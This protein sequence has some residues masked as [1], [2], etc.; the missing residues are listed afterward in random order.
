M[1]HNRSFFA[2]EL[3]NREESV[4]FQ[5]VSL[6]YHC[7]HPLGHVIRNLTWNLPSASLKSVLHVNVG[8]AV[9][10]PVWVCYICECKVF[11][12][13]HTNA[14]WYTPTVI[15]PLYL[16]FHHLMNYFFLFF[17]R[18]TWKPPNMSAGCVWPDWSFIRLTRVACKCFFFCF[19]CFLTCLA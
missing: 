3:A 4:Q 1:S 7:T 11:E 9:T 14:S 16:L 19:V 13:I 8:G 2:L 12:I 10:G 18:K 5:T 17:G 15:Q 6:C